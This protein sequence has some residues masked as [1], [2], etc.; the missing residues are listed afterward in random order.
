MSDSTGEFNARLHRIETQH[1]RLDRGYVGRIRRDGLIVFEPRRRRVAIPV[2]GLLHLI[3][4][5]VFF[6]AAV[7]V[8]LGFV[9]YE[10][11]IAQLAD[12]HAIEQA[13]AWIMQADMLTEYIALT[14]RPIFW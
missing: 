9:T 12:G 14:L 6:K 13:G 2:R 4:G 8:H 3:L 11:R 5:F 1:A 10:A 7:L